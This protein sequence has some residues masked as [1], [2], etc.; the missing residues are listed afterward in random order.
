MT[1]AFGL[2]R[3]RTFGHGSIEKRAKGSHQGAIVVHVI[4]CVLKDASS[5]LIRL[6]TVDVPRSGRSKRL[7]KWEGPARVGG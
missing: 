5:V 1:L 7:D 4:P 6:Q 2:I 3:I